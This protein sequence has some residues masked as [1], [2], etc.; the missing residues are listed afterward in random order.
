MSW[1]DT[2]LEYWWNITFDC[3]YHFQV[4]RFEQLCINLCAETLQHFYNTHMFRATEEACAEEAISAD[5]DVTYA[6]NAPTIELLSSPRVG[7]LSLLDAESGLQ[8]GTPDTFLQK[9]HIQHSRN[10]LWVTLDRPIF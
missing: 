6:D 7:L 5:I 9:V 1:S 4:N 3:V 2:Y 8:R 10:K